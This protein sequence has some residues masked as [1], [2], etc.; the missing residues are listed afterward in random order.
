MRNK[1]K[2]K[3]E[4]GYLFLCIER[5]SF[6]DGSAHLLVEDRIPLVI[7]WRGERM[8]WIEGSNAYYS[9]VPVFS[10]RHDLLCFTF[11]EQVMN[12]R[13]D[14]FYH[15]AL[16][17]G[18]G[19]GA[20]PR[21]MLE[22][23]KSISVDVVDISAKILSVCKKYFLGRYKHSRRLQLF[24]EDAADYEAAKD[25]YQFIFCDLFDGENL[26]PVVYDP[27]FARKLHGMISK[28]G[29]LVINCGWHHKDQV[30]AA[31]QPVFQY[32]W[33]IEREP[34]QTEVVMASDSLV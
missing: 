29:L 30:C 10:F 15:H 9:V 20:V 3:R 2:L 8:L 26:A 12:M 23:Y 17:L 1:I 25:R 16:V 27:A 11:C 22:T 33:S 18:C 21:W 34:W 31:Y 7:P 13:P 19:G 4:E 6:Q 28:D 24:C 5:E 32:M 14:D